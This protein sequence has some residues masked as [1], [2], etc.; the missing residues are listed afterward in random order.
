[1]EIAV[2]LVFLYSRY[3]YLCNMPSVL[4][5]C[6]RAVKELDQSS[7]WELLW[8]SDVSSPPQLVVNLAIIIL[9]IPLIESSNS[10]RNV[11]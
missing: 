7:G 11:Y 8:M 9:I 5:F 10:P 2:T 3:K 1:V 4:L 6:F